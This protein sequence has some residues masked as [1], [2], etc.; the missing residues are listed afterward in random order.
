[1]TTRNPSRSSRTIA[2]VAVASALSLAAG[3]SVAQAAR[4]LPPI[5][6]I[7]QSILTQEGVVQSTVRQGPLSPEDQAL[8]K[9]WSELFAA[10]LGEFR[11]DHRDATARIEGDFA[12]RQIRIRRTTG[13]DEWIGRTLTKQQLATV[14]VRAFAKKLYEESKR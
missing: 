2:V 1:M 11:A 13:I 5:A 4:W 3:A 9:R 10:V 14:D 8:V 7:G 12:T 6:M